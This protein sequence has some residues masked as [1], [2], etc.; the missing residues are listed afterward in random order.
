MGPPGAAFAVVRWQQGYDIG[1]VDAFMATISSRTPNQIR[2]AHF[3]THRLRPGYRIPDVDDA[4]DA[5]AASL[6]ARN[7]DLDE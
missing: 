1:E 7:T 2:K 3:S 4:L 5:W 6:E